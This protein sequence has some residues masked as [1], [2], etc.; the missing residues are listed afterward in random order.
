MRDV[1]AYLR[2]KESEASD[3]AGLATDYSTL[4]DLYS[5]RLWHQLTL[6][7]GTFVKRPELQS[8]G[9][10]IDLYENFIQDIEMR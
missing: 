6:R 4:N 5:K 7:L 8:D 1:S 10:L 2:K 3:N 9:Q